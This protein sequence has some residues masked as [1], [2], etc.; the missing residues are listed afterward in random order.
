VNEK[1]PHGGTLILSPR[2][3]P[4][5][6]SVNAKGKERLILDLRHVNEHIVLSKMKFEDVA[7]AKQFLSS[8][9]FGFVWD[10]KSGYHHV[11]IFHSHC[12][13][14]GFKW[15]MSEIKN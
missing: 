12:K 7:C 1:Y 6:V 11:D 15:N 13:Y 10:L 8:E 2:Q 14:L 4:L 5:T 3:I 9:C